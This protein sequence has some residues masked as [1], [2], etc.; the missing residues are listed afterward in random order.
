MT[1]YYITGDILPTYRGILH[2]YVSIGLFF[3]SL[4]DLS[5]LFNVYFLAFCCNANN[6][7]SYNVNLTNNDINNDDF[8]Y[9]INN[10]FNTN[11]Y[12]NFYSNFHYSNSNTGTDMD[13]FI[14]MNLAIYLAYFVGKFLSYSSSAILH[15]GENVI[16][17]IKSHY[18]WL[19][20]DKFC[21]YISVGVSGLPF[22]LNTG[23]TG[24]DSY[25]VINTASIILGFIALLNDFERM[26]NT[27]F[28][29][30]IS[31]VI[32]VLG[33]IVEYNCLWFIGT[34]FYIGGFLCFYPN[35]RKTYNSNRNSNSKK[36]VEVCLVNRSVFWHR[37]GVYGCHEDFHLLIFLGDAIYFANSL[38][39]LSSRMPLT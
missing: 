37:P 20:I 38:V 4:M 25:M 18:E 7:N 15:S 1:N 2:L 31:Y 13:Y 35:M 17:T 9:I 11:F 24:L 32:L 21:I 23:N 22:I 14:E 28:L 19:I 8:I 3:L 10:Y 5:V 34:G 27:I 12:S 30:Q 29:F 33:R 26:R 16:T 6:A 39:F 36:M